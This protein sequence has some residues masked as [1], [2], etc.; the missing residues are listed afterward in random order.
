MQAAGRFKVERL[1]IGRQAS[2]SDLLS[3]S[4]AVVI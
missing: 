3:L 4:K 1:N 2:F